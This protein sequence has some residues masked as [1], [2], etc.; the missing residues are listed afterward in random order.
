MKFALTVVATSKSWKMPREEVDRI[1]IEHRKLVSE[2]FAA[3]KFVDVRRLR[4]GVEAKTM[5]V[6]NGT[7]V[8]F[9]GPFT[10]TGE[11]V[12]AYYL[13]DTESFEEAV[14]WAGKLALFD[15]ESIEIRQLW[16]S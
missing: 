11:A 1:V 12:G 15:W 9:D 7:R 8:L 5:R 14:D 13:I 2:L 6:A 16:I 3:G 4:P 10:G